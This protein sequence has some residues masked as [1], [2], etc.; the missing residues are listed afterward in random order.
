MFDHLDDAEERTFIVD[1]TIEP[2]ASKGNRSHEVACSDICRFRQHESDLDSALNDLLGVCEFP[3]TVDFDKG[4]RKEAN[5]NP[6]VGLAIEVENAKSKYFLGS[7]LAASCTGRWGLL[8]VP[9]TPETSRWIMTVRRMIHKG[10]RSP[11]PSN[12]VIFKWNRLE[13]YINNEENVD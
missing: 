9:D 3:A 7:L 4:W 13:E 11:I 10:S 5:P 6:M 8:V 1:L 2:I 12:I